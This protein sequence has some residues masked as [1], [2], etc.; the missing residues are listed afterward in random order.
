MVL[1]YSIKGF[2]LKRKL[3]NIVQLSLYMCGEETVVGNGGFFTTFANLMIDFYK[4][5]KK[6]DTV[7]NQL[8]ITCLYIELYKASR[9]MCRRSSTL[10]S[11]ICDSVY[12]LFKIK[13]LQ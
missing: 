12:S 11:L 9:Y 7:Y 2:L 13:L 1:I 5:K 8:E 3:E 10:K 6:Y 4:K